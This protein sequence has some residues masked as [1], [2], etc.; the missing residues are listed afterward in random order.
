MSFATY[1]LAL[2]CVAHSAMISIG[3]CVCPTFPIQAK[4]IVVT[5][6]IIARILISHKSGQLVIT[7]AQLAEFNIC[8]NFNRNEKSF[9]NG[10]HFFKLESSRTMQ[11]SLY[12]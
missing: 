3:W 12:L 5:A 9:I 7:T 11:L 8:D 10:K 4:F 6:L 2:S 1:S